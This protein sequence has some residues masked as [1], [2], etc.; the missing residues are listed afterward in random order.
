MAEDRTPQDADKYIV[1]FPEGMRERL[2]NLA[3]ANNRTLNAEI[4]ARLQA[5]F[6]EP[7]QG[8]DRDVAI[9]SSTA[10]AML[11]ALDRANEHGKLL[12]KKVEAIEARLIQPEGTSLFKAGTPTVQQSG[13]VEG[14][15]RRK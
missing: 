3:K 13:G 10:E 6:T 2:K 1:R 15:T 12:L 8:V 11:K 4:I 7:A 14:L 5:S 9:A